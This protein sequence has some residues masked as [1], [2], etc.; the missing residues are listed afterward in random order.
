MKKVIKKGNAYFQCE[1]C[2][3]LYKDKTMAEKCERF[4]KKYKGCNLE[5]TKHAIKVD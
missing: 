5:I 4:C 2:L 3:L 1:E